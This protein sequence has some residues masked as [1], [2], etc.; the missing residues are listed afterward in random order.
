MIILQNLFK[1]GL[2]VQDMIEIYILYIRSVVENSSVVWHSSLT[3]ADRVAIE[4]IQKVVFKIILSEKYESYEQALKITGLPSLEERRIILCK[5]FV[6]KCLKNEKASQLFPLNLHST[7]MKTR[8]Q[9]KFYVQPANTGRFQN[10]AVP[11]MQ[12]LLN[13]MYI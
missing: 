10:S 12:R 1:F 2:P 3:I 8:K 4:R 13:T 9:E 6:R 5:K 11:Y 7:T